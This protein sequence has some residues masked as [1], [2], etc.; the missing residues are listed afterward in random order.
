MRC[1]SH[2]AV[3]LRATIFGALLLAGGLSV[4]ASVASARA[5]DVVDHR[6]AGDRAAVGDRHHGDAAVDQRD[7]QRVIYSIYRTCVDPGLAAI[8]NRPCRDEERL[9]VTDI[10]T[11]RRFAIG[12]TQ[13]VNNPLLS[14][15]GSIALWTQTYWGRPGFAPLGYSAIVGSAGGQTRPLT[16]ANGYN[17]DLNSRD[18]V[19][20]L[21]ADGL[22]LAAKT[23]N[24]NHEFAECGEPLGY[25]CRPQG[26]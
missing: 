7:G 6:S 15:D 24:F 11:G 17:L 5:G 8:E 9:G 19:E 4:G 16:D 22:T 26:H 12:T 3:H 25:G 10:R 1:T 21:S 13:P 14:A 23:S 18:S 2:S 20:G